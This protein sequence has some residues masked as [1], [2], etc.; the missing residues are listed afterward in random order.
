MGGGNRTKSRGAERAVRTIEVWVIERIE[1]VQTQL[2]VHPFRECHAFG[3]GHIPVVEAW[4]PQIVPR[5]RAINPRTRLDK[6]RGVK[7]LGGAPSES[8]VWILP[9]N[10]VGTI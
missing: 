8:A 3:Q 7:P 1:C 5:R 9:G 2:E 6:S 4:S 10:E